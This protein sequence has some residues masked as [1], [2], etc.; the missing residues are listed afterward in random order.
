MKKLE[1]LRMAIG[2][3]HE[4]ANY[5]P[6]RTIRFSLDKFPQ[7]A[8]T[9]DEFIPLSD[10]NLSD[11]QTRPGVKAGTSIVKKGK[12]KN[13]GKTIVEKVTS[14]TDLDEPE[15]QNFRSQVMHGEAA[16]EVFGG[17]L[18][19]LLGLHH[20]PTYAIKDSH[21]DTDPLKH[22][23]V[24]HADYVD[25]KPLFEHPIMRSGSGDRQERLKN[26]L[27]SLDSGSIHD[28]AL[29]NY[30]IDHRDQHTGNF[31]VTPEDKVVPLDYG[32][33]LYPLRDESLIM[34]R[35]HP[36]SESHLQHQ[37]NKP[38]NK[39]LIQK[40]VTNKDKIL[41]LL[42][43]TVL[44]HYPERARELVRGS[45]ERRLGHLQQ[46]LAHQGTTSHHLH[47]LINDEVVAN[48]DVPEKTN[49]T[50]PAKDFDSPTNISSSPDDSNYQGPTRQVPKR[51]SEFSMPEGAGS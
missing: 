44:S 25:G 9:T 18:A 32:R 51:F 24:V 33:S 15:Q 6:A 43:K 2:A 28:A 12:A 30:L 50:G 20:Y 48:H 16:R 4:E 49:Y 17:Q 21:T 45:M 14:P 42:D 1:I 34:H 26:T 13:S 22:R 41:A 5:I 36:L 31:M 8:I 7:E 39:E 23:T 46:L 37:K 29:F 38:L 11:R 40:M 10:E 47:R 3:V 19:Q 27:S 35:G